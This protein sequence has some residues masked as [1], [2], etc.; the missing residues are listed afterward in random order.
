MSTSKKKSG[1]MFNWIGW[2]LSG[3]IIF[4]TVVAWTIRVTVRMSNLSAMLLS[5]LV[6]LPLAIG[7]YASGGIAIGIIFSRVKKTSN[8][9][10]ILGWLTDI[11]DFIL[12]GLVLTLFSWLQLES[13]YSSSFSSLCLSFVILI[14]SPILIG[15]PLVGLA[16]G[17]LLLLPTLLYTRDKRWGLY[18]L[19][20]TIIVILL[21]HLASPLNA[22]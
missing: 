22:L 12:G 18:A 11:K 6:S 7:W 16:L 4:A 5:L 3:G 14:L 21:T 1:A 10:S 20:L 17:P 2:F 13:P 8:G 15:I 9:D 19:P